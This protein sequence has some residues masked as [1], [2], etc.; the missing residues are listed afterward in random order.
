MDLL[1]RLGRGR[2][3]NRGKLDSL[4]S[5]NVKVLDYDKGDYY[6]NC[7]IDLLF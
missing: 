7:I 1:L 2:Y 4:A 6:Q 3:F 5:N